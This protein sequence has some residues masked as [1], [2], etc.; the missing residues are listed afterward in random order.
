MP[1]WNQAHGENARLTCHHFG[2]SPDT[3]Y[4]SKRRYK[5]K[6]LTT[7]EARS[8]RPQ[9]VRKATWSQELEETVLELRESAPGWGTSTRPRRWRVFLLLWVPP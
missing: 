7:L 6:D 9:R 2:I 1:E 5:A 8:R 4:R 3:F